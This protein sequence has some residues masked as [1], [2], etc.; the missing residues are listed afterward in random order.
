MGRRLRMGWG[1]GL[2]FGVGLGMGSEQRCGVM[3]QAA[4]EADVSE[5]QWLSLGLPT[6]QHRG[7]IR[8]RTGP[9]KTP[10]VMDE[11]DSSP[12]RESR[13]STSH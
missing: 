10:K 1:L 5:I 4:V 2:G 11:C 13:M 6:W 8:F 3:Q 9:Q 7:R 12:P